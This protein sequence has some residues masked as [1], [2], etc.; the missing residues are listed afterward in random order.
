MLLYSPSERYGKRML[1]KARCNDSHCVNERAIKKL[2]VSVVVVV[3][4]FRLAI[5]IHPI[6]HN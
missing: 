1:L 6:S 4:C 5:Y 3:T 2:S